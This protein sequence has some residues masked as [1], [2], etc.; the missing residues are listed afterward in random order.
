MRPGRNSRR[1]YDRNGNMQKPETV[2]SSRALGHR[3]A[4]V[5]CHTCHHHAEIS[6]DGLP[7]DLPIPDI[8]LRYRCSSCGGKDLMSRGSIAEHYEMIEQRTGFS[9]GNRKRGIS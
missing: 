6:M 9:L 3:R 2:G 5:W 7:D 1:A 4:E 8:C